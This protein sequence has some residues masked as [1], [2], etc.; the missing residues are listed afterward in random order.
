MTDDQILEEHDRNV[1]TVA[2]AVF[3]LVDRFAPRGMTPLGVFEGAVRGA[4]LA[5]ALRQG[6]SP[7]AIADMLDTYAEGFRNM[8]PDAFKPVPN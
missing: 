6:D 3:G 5:M 2:E 1:Q 8:K 4:A 7:Q